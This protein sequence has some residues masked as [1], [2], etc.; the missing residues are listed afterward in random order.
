MDYMFYNC[1]KFNKPLNSW[2]VSSVTNMDYMFQNCHEFNQ[3]LDKW[4]LKL[5]NEKD[6]LYISGLIV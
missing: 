2:D 6:R 4:L 5:Q 1:N 3:P